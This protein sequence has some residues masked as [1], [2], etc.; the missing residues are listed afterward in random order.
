MDFPSLLIS[1]V[2][3]RGYHRWKEEISVNRVISDFHR[4]SY[5]ILKIIVF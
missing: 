2:K 1:K 4:K 3:K 5:K